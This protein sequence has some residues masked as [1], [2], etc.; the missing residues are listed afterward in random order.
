MKKKIHSPLERRLY[1]LFHSLWIKSYIMMSV[2]FFFMPENAS[3][4]GQFAEVIF[5]TSEGNQLSYVQNCYFIKIVW[6]FDEP[7]S[8]VKCRLK[9]KIYFL[10]FSLMKN[11]VSF[12]SNRSIFESRS[13][14]PV[15][16]FFVHSIKTEIK[17]LFQTILKN[18][19]CLNYFHFPLFTQ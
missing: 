6:S 7:H 11:I 3:F 19:K 12:E 17:K 18:S 13:L 14:S 5:D 8:Q 4:Q 2:I 15:H 10:N 9:N 16:F 1:N